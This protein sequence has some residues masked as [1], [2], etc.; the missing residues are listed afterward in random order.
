M[1]LKTL[2]R[3]LDELD[4]GGAGP[5]TAGTPPILKRGQV[6]STLSALSRDVRARARGGGRGRRREGGI[7]GIGADDVRRLAR[8]VSLLRRLRRDGVVD[9]GCYSEVRMPPFVVSVR[10]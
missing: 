8:V 6:F 7:G 2:E 5:G 3:I 4:H 9:P 10:A 1:A